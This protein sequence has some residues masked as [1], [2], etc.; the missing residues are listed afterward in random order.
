MFR[1]PTDETNPTLTETRVVSFREWLT[2][3][4]AQRAGWRTLRQ[5]AEV[6]SRTTPDARNAVKAANEAAESGHRQSEAG[7][8]TGG[9]AGAGSF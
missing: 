4:R 8:W 7:P 2:T 1:V 9:G 6:A 5:A 3:G